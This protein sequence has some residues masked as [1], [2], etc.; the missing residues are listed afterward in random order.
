[1][2]YSEYTRASEAATFSD[3]VRSRAGPL[4]ERMVR[5]R[6]TLDVTSDQLP[7][8][9]WR[10][11]LLYEH[12]FVE[13]AVTIFG[14]ALVKAPSIAEQVRLSTVLHELTTDQIDYFDRVFEQLDVAPAERLVPFPPAAV[15]SFRDGMLALAAHGTYDEIIGG[16][17]AAEWMYLTWCTAAHER[18]HSDATIVDW[19][20]L[21][22]SP[23]FTDQV[24][25]MQGQL[26][27]YGPELPQR[28]QEAV[29]R[30]FQ[31]TLA[32]EIGFHHAAY[33]DGGPAEG[34]ESEDA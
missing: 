3:W 5:H 18:P 26:D 19:V 10:R 23:G 22:V 4:W 32:L 29:A 34:L 7:P 16:M 25:W 14:Y 31:H 17:A 15:S 21:H 28:H 13:T 2:N 8:Q 9:V 1:M 24:T 30:A 20:A 11:Y 27:R 33:L 12:A 6:F